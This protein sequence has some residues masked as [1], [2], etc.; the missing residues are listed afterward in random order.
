MAPKAPLVEAMYH[1][2]VS[3]FLVATMDVPGLADDVAPWCLEREVAGFVEFLDAHLCDLLVSG[4]W[5]FF[6]PF[7]DT[8]W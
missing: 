8:R 1:N 5:I 6:I 4:G 2:L 3:K 7:R